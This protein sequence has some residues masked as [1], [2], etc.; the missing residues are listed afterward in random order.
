[1]LICI[2]FYYKLSILIDVTCID[3]RKYIEN[4]NYVS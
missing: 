1:M 3:K 2:L 4:I